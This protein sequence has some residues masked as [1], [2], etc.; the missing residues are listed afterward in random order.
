MNKEQLKLIAEEK[1]PTPFHHWLKTNWRAYKYKLPWLKVYFGSLRRLTP[2]SREFGY[3]RGVPIDRYYIENFL[4]RYADD[5]QGRVLEIED[6][7]YSR[8][9][10]GDRVTTR[11]VLHIEEGNPKAT[12]VGDLTNADHIPS[13]TFDCF[14]LTQTLHLIYDFRLA[15]KTI[16]RI[17]KPGG[18]LLATFPGIS[19]C[20]NDQ[21]SDYWCWAFT[22][23]SAQLL[24]E[25]FFPTANVKV[26]TFGNVLATIAF[27]QGLSVQELSQKELDYRDHQYQLL[28]TV[29]AMKPE[30]LDELT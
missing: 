18:V 13:D 16:Y 30:V 1:L 29:R 8:Q 3:D 28:I 12:F 17:L 5:I 26:E 4:S 25:E 20:S 21:W 22:S 11:D 15:I 9:F 6:D 7:S 27:L 10:G 23:K 14:V 24:F 2:I 19:Q